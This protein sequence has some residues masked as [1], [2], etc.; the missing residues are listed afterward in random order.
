[1]ALLLPRSSPTTV[2]RA[3]VAR[4]FSRCYSPISGEGKKFN[5]LARLLGRQ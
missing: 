2:P 1:M 4:F 3:A 5:D